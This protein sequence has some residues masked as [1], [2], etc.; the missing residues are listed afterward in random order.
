MN[1]IAWADRRHFVSVR[2]LT[3]YVTL[4]MT[5]R[6]FAWAAAFAHTTTLDGL[7]TAA[8]IGA[9]TAPISYLQK[10][11]FDA[12]MRGKEVTE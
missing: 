7:A 6:A 8:V 2:A 10:T 3:L 11:V 12:Y 5:W 9:V 1:F 4:W